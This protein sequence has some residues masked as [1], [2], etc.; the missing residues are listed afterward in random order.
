VVLPDTSVWVEFSR[1]GAGGRAAALAGL[2]DDGDVATCGPVAAELV[3]G[4]EGEIAERIWETLISLPWAELG[5]AGWREI[6]TTA[7]RLRRDGRTLPL[8][9]LVIAVTA[10][11]AGHVLWSFD[12]DFERIRDALGELELYG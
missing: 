9:G 6:G 2:L 11:R 7:A 1:R 4:A 10:A 3:A 12:S 8:T 5:A